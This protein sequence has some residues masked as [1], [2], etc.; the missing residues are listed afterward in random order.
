MTRTIHNDLLTEQ[1]KLAYTP[2]LALTLRDNGLPHP[3]LVTTPAASSVSGVTASTVAGTVIVRARRNSGGIEIQRITDPTS[4]S[5]WNSWTTLSSTTYRLYPALFYTGTYVVLVYQGQNPFPKNVYWRRSSDGG[6][7]W[8]SEQTIWTPTYS[9][10]HHQVGVSGGA[11]RSALFY[12]AGDEGADTDTKVA[13]RIYNAAADSWGSEISKDYAGPTGL[14]IAG[15]GAIY[16]G[17]DL[18]RYAAILE[19]YTAWATASVIVA[20][21]DHDA[22]TFGDSYIHQDIHGVDTSNPIYR[23][24]YANLALVDGAYWLSFYVD[25]ADSAAL[26]QQGDHLLAYS[27]DGRHYTGGLKLGLHTLAD[28]VQPLYWSTTGTTYLA[29]DSKILASSGP[30]TL[31]ADESA[32]IRY[33]LTDD[34]PEATLEVVLDNRAG[35]LDGIET[36]RLGADLVLE[37]GAKIGDVAR[38]VGRE[39]FVLARVRWSR[40]NNEVTLWGYSYYRLLRLWRAQFGYVFAPNADRA[41]LTL[42]E[43]VEAVAALAGLH[44]ANFDGAS[45]WADTIAQFIIQPGQSALHA[46]EGLM[47]Q[48]QFVCRLDETGTLDCFQIAAAPAAAYTFGRAAGEHP[49]LYAESSSERAL[50]DLTHVMVLGE[51]VGAEAA[52]SAI[53]AEA[54][55]QHTRLLTRRYLTS[56][57]QATA[58][59]TAFIT[60]T[61]QSV[62]RARL[63][64]LPAFHLE[65]YDVVSSDGWANDQTRYITA[66]VEKYQPGGVRPWTQR[67][68]L[69]NLHT[70]TIPSASSGNAT[71]GALVSEQPALKRGVVVSFDGVTQTALIRIVGSPATFELS[72][73]NWVSSLSPDD[74][75]AVLLFDESNPADG[76]ILGSY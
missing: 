27:D 19:N 44:A 32:I 11:D 31:T 9:L 2:S 33:T 12:V 22:G 54:G 30:A 60:Q 66:L 34:G 73:G 8:S 38:R 21:Y 43:V 69:G 17:N 1:K 56:D 58:A 74:R 62:S 63:E 6:Q 52:A 70:A 7:S 4:A 49:T 64:C 40:D 25:V 35:T 5:Q 67:L 41:S 3:T 18:Y 28:R 71:V 26:L 61:E 15:L 72:V 10:N 47:A 16:D 68:T 42:Q 20:E 65:L 45:I 29:G 51:G 57:S 55:R 75:V 36:G 13:L 23:L 50:P 37:R 76:L 53:Q 24:L 46:L 59:A 39:P 14:G 48:F